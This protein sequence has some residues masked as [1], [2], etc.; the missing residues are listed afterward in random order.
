MPPRR[1]HWERKGAS[2]GCMD[3]A[4]GPRLKLQREGH[5]KQASPTPSP[6][7]LSGDV[8]VLEGVVL[9]VG[10]RVQLRPAGPPA[11]QEPTAHARQDAP[12]KPGRQTAGSNRRRSWAVHMTPQL[13]PQ[14]SRTFASGSINSSAGATSTLHASSRWHLQDALLASVRT[15]AS[16]DLA[17]AMMRNN[18]GAGPHSPVQ[19]LRVVAPVAAVVAP[20]EQGVQGARGNVALPCADHVPMAHG[21]QPGPPKPAR[22]TAQRASDAGGGLGIC[23]CLDG[24]W[25][26]A[27]ERDAMLASPVQLPASVPPVPAVV[28]PAG[29]G[30]QAGCGSWVEPPADHEPRLHIAVQLGPP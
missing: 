11:L 2:T 8:L 13:H 27:S 9:P 25:L 12:P 16:V 21:S 26:T 7:Q 24:W 28:V 5:W 15:Y 18:G 20:L 14:C 29:Q 3:L 22:H 10:H 17:S 30:E 6:E 4:G 23:V 1:H 19:L